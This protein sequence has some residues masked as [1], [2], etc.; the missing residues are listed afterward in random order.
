[1]K[2]SNYGIA[3]SVLYQTC[4]II[5]TNCKNNLTAFTAFASFYT[6]SFIAD[7]EKDVENAEKMPSEQARALEHEKLRQ[8]MVAIGK[9]C[10]NMWQGL[11]RYI[12]KAYAEEFWVMNW[13]A[14][15]W[16]NYEAASNENWDKIIA[17]MN[18]G[19]A[20]ITLHAAELT[21]MPA[22]FV[23]DF[24]AAKDAMQAKFSAF[25]SA[26]SAASIGTDAKVTANND[27]YAKVVEVCLDGQYIFNDDDTMKELFSFEK[28]SEL[29]KPVGAAGLKGTVTKD[30]VP[31]AGIIVELEE[32][33]KSVITDAEG[34]FNFGNQLASG[35]DTIILKKG[36]EILMEED[37]TIPAGVT[38]KEDIELPV[39]PVIV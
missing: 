7:L 4:R 31:Q 26:E 35:T 1:M 19:S 12:T 13:D 16:N 2:K 33:N 30:G 32:G 39:T 17:M 6:V 10:R 20:Y 27:V 25:T 9:T 22:G 21:D 28:M 34:A 5:L 15:G 11:K 38:K 3:Q 8:E 36:D 18:E 14:A 23:T 37:V 29:V 24:N